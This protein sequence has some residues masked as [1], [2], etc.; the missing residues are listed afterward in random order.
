MKNKR[1]AGVILLAAVVMLTLSACKPAF[2]YDEDAAVEAAKGIVGDINAGDYKAVEDEM[3][4][5]MKAALPAAALQEAVAPVLEESGPFVEF[6]D[7]STTGVTQN[8]VNYIV[9]AVSCQYEQTTRIYTISLTTDM[10][11]G[12]LYVK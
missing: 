12:G 5:D 3:T 1:R 2:D 10:K 9:V 11:I 8:G 4:D 6:K 7:T